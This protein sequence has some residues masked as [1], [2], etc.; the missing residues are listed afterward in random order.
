MPAWGIVQGNDRE[1]FLYRLGHY[2]QPS[3]HVVRYTLRIDGFVSVEAPYS[4]GSMTTK[5]LTFDGAGLYIN[6]A[7][8]AA[9]YV[10]VEVQD[11]SG[12]PLP[13]FSLEEATELVGDRIRHRVTWGE[14]ADVSALVGKPVRLKFEMKTR[15]CIR[16]SL[17]RL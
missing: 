2:A 17:N 13:G 12:D 11:L 4:G 1:L 15:T 16:L 3:S 8:S 14:N 5:A 6:F 9:G 7:T 10:K